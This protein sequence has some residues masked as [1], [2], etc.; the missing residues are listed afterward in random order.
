MTAYCSRCGVSFPRN[1]DEAW[2]KLCLP[3]WKVGASGNRSPRPPPTVRVSA[4]IDPEM[5]RRLL[6]LCHPDKHNNSEAAIKAT[7]WL[8]QQRKD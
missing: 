2:K 6:F 7:Q 1:E 4:P 8:L 5:L 3:C